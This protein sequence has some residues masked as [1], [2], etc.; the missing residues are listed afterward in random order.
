[1]NMILASILLLTVPK[2]VAAVHGH[3]A[4]SSGK[5]AAGA[6]VFLQGG[7]RAKP[8]A[9]ATVDQRDRMFSPHVSVVTVGTKVQFPNHDTV[10]HNVFADFDAKK[11]DL[12]MYP[13][14]ASRTKSF[15]KAGLVVLMCSVHPE[16]SAYIMV[17]DT[18][19]YAVADRSG[20]FTIPNV[21]SGPYTL[22][23]WHESGQTS[24][25]GVS[26]SGDSRFDCKTRRG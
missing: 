23:V 3:V 25:S 18:P 19:F 17:V 1:M 21:P 20:N 26:V 24:S 9:N 16:M 12:G 22:R 6:V 13:R 7:V 10:F 14:G 8:L 11:F 2:P 5:A 15:D 4:L